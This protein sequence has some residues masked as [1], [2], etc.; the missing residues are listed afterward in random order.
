[1]T[2]VFA[3]GMLANLKRGEPVE[4]DGL[5]DIT[6]EDLVTMWATAG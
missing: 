5:I 2:I 1:M 4:R 3:E 6:L